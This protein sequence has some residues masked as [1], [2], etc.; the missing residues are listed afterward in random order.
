MDEPMKLKTKNGIAEPMPQ[1]DLQWNN[2]LLTGL[3]V[4]MIFWTLIFLWAVWKVLSTGAVNN[5]IA[6]CV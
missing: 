4:I 6:A 3:L 2:R 1:S 5:Y